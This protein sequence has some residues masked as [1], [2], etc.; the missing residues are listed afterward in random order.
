MSIL[1]RAL[2]R[3]AR[4][5]LQSVITQ[6]NQ[7]FDIVEDQALNPMRM[8]IQAVTGGIW[9]GASADAFVNEVSSIMIPEVGVVGH[10]ITTINGNIQTAI[11][12][13]DQA[14]QQVT[15]MVNNLGDVFERV[16]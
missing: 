12:I 6:L 5:I 3:L 13:L 7:Q 16:F 8:M 11:E 4:R 14:D 10:N 2:I 15:S 9:I 1:T